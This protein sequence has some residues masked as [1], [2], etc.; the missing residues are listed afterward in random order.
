ML[1]VDIDN[2]ACSVMRFLVQA[3]LRLIV[4]E[5]YPMP[6]F[7]RHQDV[8]YSAPCAQVTFLWRPYAAN[9]SSELT[10]WAEQE[11]S[12]AEIVVSGAALW[13]V[14][15]VHSASQYRDSLQSTRDAIQGLL[16]Q[17]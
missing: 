14:L 11:N 9:V 6:E 17:V 5:E 1:Q 3:V 13:D 2:A 4:S 7:P 8:V 15:H 16:R 12:E 10:A